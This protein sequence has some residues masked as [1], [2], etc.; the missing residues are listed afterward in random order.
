[1]NPE[2]AVDVVKLNIM[3]KMLFN[4]IRVSWYV[5]SDANIITNT[6]QGQNRKFVVL[7]PCCCQ[8]LLEFP[9]DIESLAILC[10]ESDF[11]V[12]RLCIITLHSII[13]VC[14]IGAGSI[15][16]ASIVSVLKRFDINLH[17][18]TISFTSNY[19]FLP[20]LVS[21]VLGPYG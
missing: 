9:L 10:H 13:F 2:F 6:S 4:S 17:G 20:P 8:K 18:T 1:V 16:S 3:S 21:S 7:L 12:S 14:V 15:S 11:D 5:C 19:S